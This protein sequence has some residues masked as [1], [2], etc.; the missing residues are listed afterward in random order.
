MSS[1]TKAIP[2]SLKIDRNDINFSTSV[3]GTLYGTTPGGTKI[4]YDRNTLLQYRNSP[5]SKTP[6]PEL[7]HLTEAM[8]SKKPIASTPTKPVN[9]PQPTPTKPTDEEMFQME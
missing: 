6:P 2:V 3:G 5:L 7:A 8:R 4:V 9:P 1:T